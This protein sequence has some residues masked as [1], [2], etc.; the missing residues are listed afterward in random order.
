MRKL[1]RVTCSYQRRYVNKGLLMWRERNKPVQVKAGEFVEVIEE[2]DD[3]F[4]CRYGDA[5]LR[6]PKENFANVRTKVPKVLR[7]EQ[8]EEAMV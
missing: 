4:L 2:Y 1:V 5:V 3:S 7:E 8:P 6:I